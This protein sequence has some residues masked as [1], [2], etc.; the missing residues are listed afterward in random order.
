MNAP[1]PSILPVGR[2]D[3]GRPAL[4][5]LVRSCVECGLCLPHCATYLATGNEVQSPRGRILLLGEVVAGRL[6]ARDPSV[7]AAFDR[8][9]GCM[10]CTAVCPSGIHED[11]MTQIQR[12]GH[13]GTDPGKERVARWLDRPAILSILRRAATLARLLLRTALGVHWRRRLARAV[14]PLPRL[15]RRLGTLPTG[16]GADRAL[17]ERIDALLARRGLPVPAP[18]PARPQHDV[19]DTG[20]P[21]PGAPIPSL[22]WFTGCADESLLP[23]TARRLRDLARALGARVDIP[24][25]QGCCGALAAH[26]Q[27]DG[28]AA[29]LSRRNAEAFV[30]TAADTAI[31]VA[32]SGC[33]RHLAHETSPL[34]GRV[35][36]AVA[37]VESLLQRFPV[38]LATIPLRVAVHDPCHGRDGREPATAPR[39]VLGRIPGLQIVEPSEATVCC[40]AGG[41]YSLR[42]ARLSATMGARKAG[43]LA[44]TGCDLVV[45]TNAG[46]L[47]QIADGLE[48]RAEPVPVLPLTDLLWYAWRRGAGRESP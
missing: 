19:G 46:C 17:L 13:E 4:D 5:D 10:A 8:C 41:T 28:R 36:D 27:D 12:L 18:A 39:A 1:G 29:R 15:A 40:G 22:A 37:A 2:P 3:A 34:A 16:P 11:L 43:V 47:G 31:V 30:G 48:Q 33:H 9:L 23:D 20:G 44:A 35:V 26:R 45:T 6:S 32:S 38:P 42:H 14:A 25:G 21:A 24:D 7:A